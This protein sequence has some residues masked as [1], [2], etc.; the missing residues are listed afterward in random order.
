[1]T[2]ASALNIWAESWAQFMWRSL[3]EAAVLLIAVSLLWVLIHKKAS[4]QLG[5]GL[6]LLV[7]L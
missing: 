6:F 3:I 5:Y 4:A 7:L 2:T 1:M